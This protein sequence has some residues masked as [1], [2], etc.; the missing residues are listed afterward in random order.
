MA[1]TVKTSLDVKTGIVVQGK[2]VGVSVTT[3]ETFSGDSIVY[4]ADANGHVQV[5]IASASD[6]DYVFKQLPLTQFGELYTTA[7]LPLTVSGANLIFQEI[8][9]FMAGQYF[10]LPQRTVAVPTTA[11]TYFVYIAL[12]LGTPTYVVSATAIGETAIS[13][14]IGTVTMLNGAITA[15]TISK[16]SR[17]DVY[18]PSTTQRGGAFPVSTGNPQQTGT[19]SW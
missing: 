4:T 5:P 18:R 13:A 8:P 16:V 11:G 3:T 1:Y 19:I 15:N 2:N 10:T 6:V 7:A 14:F 12:K 17:F 9:L